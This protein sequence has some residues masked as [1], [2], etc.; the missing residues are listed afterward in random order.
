MDHPV[1][2]YGA[3]RNGTALLESSERDSDR[4]FLW[5]KTGGD[6][7]SLQGRTSSCTGTGHDD[8]D[9]VFRRA[10][11]TETQIGDDRR[12]LMNATVDS[13]RTKREPKNNADPC[14]TLTG[15]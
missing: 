4:G 1:F 2:R 13:G 10:V 7:P 6:G 11:Q 5:S 9:D 3:C 8:V 14:L 15:A 12:L